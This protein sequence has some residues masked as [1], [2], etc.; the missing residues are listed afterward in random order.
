MKDCVR[1]KYPSAGVELR[2]IYPF[3]IH[4]EIIVGD[5]DVKFFTYKF[6]SVYLPNILSRYSQTQLQC[7]RE[8]ERD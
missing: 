6:E 5:S 2:F 3:Y 1:F 7:P 8:A 4:Y